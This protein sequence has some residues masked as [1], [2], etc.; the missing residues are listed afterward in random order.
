MYADTVEAFALT[1]GLNIVSDMFGTLC[2]VQAEGTQAFKVLRVDRKAKG[3][4]VLGATLYNTL[5]AALLHIHKRGGILDPTERIVSLT[6][7][8]VADAFCRANGYKVSDDSH[9]GYMSISRPIQDR[10][11]EWKVARRVGRKLVPLDGTSPDRWGSLAKVR[12][13]GGLEP[14]EHLRGPHVFPYGNNFAKPARK[15][16]EDQGDKA[17]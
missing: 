6:D 15:A 7:N 10:V 1:N 11:R 2:V 5:E 8:E 13:L 14:T 3:G 12:Q 4:I 9:A 17:A 16:A